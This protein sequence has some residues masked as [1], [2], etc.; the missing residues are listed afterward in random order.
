[1]SKPTSLAL[2]IITAIGGFID[3]GELV[4]CSQAGAQYRFALLWTI[5]VGTLGIIVYTDTAGRVAIASGRSLFDVIRDRLGFRL[6]LIPLAGALLVNVL[7]LVIELAGMALVLQVITG[8]S[9]LWLYPL[10]ALIITLVL[11]FASFD[12]V[13]NAASLLGL[14]ILVFVVAAI[15]LA[16]PWH[17]VAHQAI[18]PS[19][20]KGR[21]LAAY[22]FAAISLLGAF[23]T[24]YEI[25]FYS[26]GAIEEKWSGEDIVTNRA[27]AFVGMG[28]GAIIAVGMMVV[29]AQTFYAHHL[30][31]QSFGAIRVPLVYAL[32]G[33][34]LVGFVVGAFAC[35]SGAALETA[36]STAYSVCQFFGW[37][38]GQNHN[39]KDAPVFTLWYLLAILAALVIGITGIDP[40]KLTIYTTA[41]AAFSLPFTF[42]PLLI[43]ANDERYMGEQRNSR[44]ANIA[45]LFFLVVLTIVTVATIP[46]FIM[47]G[48]GGS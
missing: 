5:V 43:I 23:M 3:M 18:M 31:P 37:D 46:L 42:A 33:L 40:I 11:W 29:A 13:E 8:L 6:A 16:A 14:A 30:Q 35:T 22:G 21:S 39:P 15:K 1:M 2:G 34:G 25:Y 44:L 9:Y 48:G 45:S 19:I 17:E 24:P 7:T 47:S 38:W 26:S 10:A 28:F 32:G 20:P 12:F 41:L 27:T 36:L 4:T